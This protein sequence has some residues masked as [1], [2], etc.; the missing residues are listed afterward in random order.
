MASE[1]VASLTITAVDKTAAAFNSISSNLGK[2]QGGLQLLGVALSAGAF[3]GFVKSTIDAADQINDLSA[4]VGIGIKEL[5]GYKLAAEQSGTSLESVAKGIK[6]LATYFN[7][8][9][10]RLKA[11]GITAKTADEAMIQLADTFAA[12]PDGLQKTTLAT[13]LFGK[14]GMEMIPMLNLG[15]RGLQ[16]AKDKAAAYGEKMAEL[17]P[18]ADRFNDL[19]EELK[20]SSSAVGISIATSMLP[21]MT[22][23]TKAM[24]EA[25][26]EGS[27]LKT[28]WVGLGGL[29]AQIFN[30]L[31][32]AVKQVGASASE[33]GAEFNE[34][35]ASLSSG[36]PRQAFLKTAIQERQNAKRI[37]AE[38]TA[39]GDGLGLD[40]PSLADG[41]NNVVSAAQAAAAARRAKALLASGEL[42][43]K[44]A[45]TYKQLTQSIAEYQAQLTAQ[46]EKQGKLTKADELAIQAKLKL[47]VAQRAQLQ[48]ALDKIAA[49][50]RE[51]ALQ[52]ALN[53]RA[54]EALAAAEKETASIAAQVLAQNEQNDTIGLTKA[55]IDLLEASR[56]DAQI[57]A[58]QTLLDIFAEND[59][60]GAQVLEIQKQID[61]LNELKSARLAGAARQTVADEA[62]K[63]AEEWKRFTDDIERSLTDSLM[64]GFEGGKDAGKNFV[65]SL[66]NT[67]KAAALK[68]VVQA[69]VNPVMGSV[70][71]AFTSGVPGTA[72]GGATGGSLS[73]LSSLSQGNSAAYAGFNSFA[74]SSIG[75]TLGLANTASFVGPVAPGGTAGLGLTSLGQ[76]I[77]GALP[78]LPA[79]T[80]ALSGNYAQAGFAAVGAAIG[81]PIGGVIGSFVGGLFGGGGPDPHD[82]TD[83]TSVGFKLSKSGVAGFGAGAFADDTT[84]FTGGAPFSTTSGY[85]R[86]RS[87]WEDNVALPQAT[88]AAINTAAAQ[89]FV[90]GANLASGLGLDPHI[91]DSAAVANH[92]FSTVEAALSDLSDAIVTKVIPN[93]KD[94]QQANEKLG[95]TATRLVAEFNLT[96]L[97]ARMRGQTG[98]QT[99]GSGLAGRDQ[100]VQLLGGTSN[101]SSAIGSYYQ[102]FYTDAER[103]KNAQGEISATLK[104]LGIS[105]AVDTREQFRAIVEAQDLATE[106][107]RKMYASLVSIADAFAGITDVATAAA[108]AT[109]N[110]FT[111]QFKTRADYIFAQKTGILPTYAA[112]GDHAG[113]WAIVGEQGPELANLGPSRVY[114]HNNSR[115]LLDTTALQNEIAAL[116]SDLRAGQAAMAHSLKIM[117]KK[118]KQWD[119]DGMPA[120]RA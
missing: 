109:N 69:I 120:V 73:L 84:G 71:G 116:R 61:A 25:A 30:P 1:N 92:A 12:M 24:A 27:T 77:Q 26:K 111:D 96:N 16:E 97:I 93:I 90:G 44:S 52:E 108:A 31:A 54:A 60:R 113:G 106:S 40:K 13:Q 99:F 86:G 107:G 62:K 57:A 18:Q 117:E 32:A 76:G 70:Q 33:A 65:D 45:D 39:L 95:D 66:K 46:E 80:A 87:R 100:L 48:P 2:L 81:G 15:S 22:E 34:F 55:Q 19:L 38:I 10:D 42:A 35:L 91:V 94:F 64:R 8:H 112:G 118:I 103:K 75:Q 51:L 115:T 104:S 82:N 14:A 4:K 43:K 63:T 56:L 67:L 47:T 3:V 50:E 105:Q 20:L 72:A 29:G 98:T 41:K 83:T 89:L 101:A 102:N 23:I 88:L 85:T 11:A 119:G 36:N 68:I 78:Y 58:K 37:Y 79:I 6:G 110:L 49:D 59:G 53:K 5:A 9:A 7:E 114:S 21:A 74:G 28:L 17:A